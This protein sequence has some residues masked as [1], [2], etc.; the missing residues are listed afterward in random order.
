M[1]T[2]LATSDID[3]FTESQ[4]DIGIHELKIECQFPE[5]ITLACADLDT[6]QCIKLAITA[7]MSY[8]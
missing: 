8:S 3:L 7:V 6:V 5:F 2:I 1:Y 4:I